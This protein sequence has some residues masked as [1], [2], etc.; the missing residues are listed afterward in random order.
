MEWTREVG[1]GVW[2]RPRLGAPGTVSGTAAGGFEAYARILHPF[3]LDRGDSTPS[4][5]WAELAGRTGRTLHPLSQAA[6]LLGSAEQAEVD[7]WSVGL[8]EQ[9]FLDPGSLAALVGP[10]AAATTRP[11]DVTI[12]VWDGWGDLHPGSGVVFGWDEG[13]PLRGARL[14]AAQEDYRESMAS[15]LDPGVARAA[16]RGR[17]GR[18]SRHVL[19]TPGRAYV[20]LRG[21]LAEL[22]DPEWPRAAGIGWRD[23]FPGP[24]PALI[25]PADHAWCVASEIDFDSTIVAGPRD[26]VDAVLAAPAV[27]A[28]E[29][30]EH[31]DLTWDGDPV[32]PTPRR[33]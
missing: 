18:A 25:W 21:T 15:A 1:R 23:G 10:L 2:L 27:E 16:R 29:V 3:R 7:G 14:R 9:G 32:N 30:P 24:M 17:S 20:L 5:T 11:D 4:W 33:S 12:G 28:L 31:G 8:P 13:G 6:N 26:L 22:A 19:Q